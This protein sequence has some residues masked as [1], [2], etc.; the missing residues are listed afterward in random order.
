MANEKKSSKAV[1]DAAKSKMTDGEFLQLL[2]PLQVALVSTQQWLME[3]GAKV[4]IVLEGRDAAG[5]DGT[6]KRMIEHMSAR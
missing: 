4:L 2:E 3:T 1:N 5:K 6:I